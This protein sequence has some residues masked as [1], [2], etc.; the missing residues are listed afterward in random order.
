MYETRKPSPAAKPG[1]KEE[2]TMKHVISRV[3]DDGAYIY[4]LTNRNT[5]DGTISFI[6]Q[7]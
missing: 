4:K 6:V 7:E 5:K 2:K 3:E 1:R